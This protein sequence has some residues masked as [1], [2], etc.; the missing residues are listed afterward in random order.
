[1]LFLDRNYDLMVMG[2]VGKTLL[3][4]ISDRKQFVRRLEILGGKKPYTAIKDL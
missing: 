1:M 4:R 3:L 2:N